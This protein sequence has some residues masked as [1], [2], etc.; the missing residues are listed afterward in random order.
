MS[1]LQILAF[2]TKPQN[3]CILNIFLKTIFYFLSLHLNTQVAVTFINPSIALLAQCLL[4]VSVIAGQA[5]EGA[6]LSLMA[7]KAAGNW[8]KVWIVVDATL[9]LVGT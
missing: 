4:P 3:K 6:L 2:K 9:V 7:D 5:E 8:L 1:S